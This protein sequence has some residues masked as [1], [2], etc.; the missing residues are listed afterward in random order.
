MP[1]VMQRSTFRSLIAGTRVD[2]AAIDAN[3]DWTGF[4]PSIPEENP[5]NFRFTR[6]GERPFPTQTVL[7]RQANKITGNASKE[8]CMSVNDDPP[9]RGGIWM[10]ALVVGALVLMV[11]GIVVAL[12]LPAP[13]LQK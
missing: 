5:P 13:V 11:G 3:L 6:Q 10:I 1:A 9:Q 12:M 2:D 4:S 7:V 8:H